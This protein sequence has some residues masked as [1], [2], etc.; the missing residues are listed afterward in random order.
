[1][2]QVLQ[3][4]GDFP[5][6]ITVY[7]NVCFALER[8]SQANPSSH[9]EL[10]NIPLSLGKMAE[11]YIKKEDQQK[12]LAC[13]QCQKKFFEYIASNMPNLESE[14][15]ADGASDLPEH[16]LP[17]LF[18][19]MHAA[20]EM[21]DAP[22]PRD[23]QEV[24]QMVLDAKKK[25]E[26]E[27]ATANLAKLKQIMAEREAKKNTSRWLQTLDYLDQHPI[28]VTLGAVVF[29]LVFLGL[30]MISFDTRKMSDRDKKGAKK[31][32]ARRPTRG[33]AQRANGTEPPPRDAKTTAEELQKLKDTL[34]NLRKKA[35]RDGL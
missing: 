8:V 15:S 28:R 10:H 12:A 3:I 6:A 14:N 1:M 29:M 11:I 16:H 32:S 34:E 9:V 23:P 24:V 35:D 19:E 4:R 33:P 22:P 2:A 26:Q 13:I 25:Y 5:R 27:Q 7:Q 17:D 31:E 30:T 20:F 18:R 21:A